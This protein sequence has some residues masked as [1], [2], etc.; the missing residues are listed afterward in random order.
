[1]KS[2]SHNAGGALYI[3]RFNC[4]T[5]CFTKRL[6]PER[7]EKVNIFDKLFGFG[8][9]SSFGRSSMS[10]ETILVEDDYESSKVSN[11]LMV[12]SG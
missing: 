4:K 8:R 6:Y 5:E 2:R 7:Q 9:L 10:G 1:M 3:R 11:I 12:V